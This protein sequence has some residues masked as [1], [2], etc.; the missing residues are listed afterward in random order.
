MQAHMHHRP[1]HH[2]RNICHDVL[3]AEVVA[4]R[5]LVMH[6]L[7]Y[8]HH[9]RHDGADCSQDKANTEVLHLV[10]ACPRVVIFAHCLLLLALRES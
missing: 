8:C 3:P 6:L 4:F 1:Q 9:H 7:G 2:A 5:P 10:L